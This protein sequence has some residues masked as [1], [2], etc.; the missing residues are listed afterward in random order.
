VRGSVL[1]ERTR[2]AAVLTRDVL[3]SD[4]TRLGE[5]PGLEELEELSDLDVAAYSTF[6]TSGPSEVLAAARARLDDRSLVPAPR[7]EIGESAMIFSS[8]TALARLFGRADRWGWTDTGVAHQHVGAV[9]HGDL[10][11]TRFRRDD[12]GFDSPEDETFELDQSGA[13]MPVA[14]EPI[15][16]T[17]ILPREPPPSA[18]YP[19]LIIGHG[20]GSSRHAMVTFAEPLT[21]AGYALVGIDMEGHG[22]RFDPDD[23]VN[24]TSMI[25]GS[26]AG[27]SEM[28][29]GF[30]DLTGP[31]TTLAL[32]EGLQNLSAVRDSF[33]QSVL[34][35]SQLAIALRTGA[36][37]GLDAKLDA[38]HLAYLGESFGSVIGGVLAGVEPEIELYVLDVGG[39]GIIDIIVPASPLLSSLLVPLGRS[40]YGIEGSFDRFHPVVALV[41]ALLDPA[42]PLTYAPHY[43]RDRLG[44]GPRHVVVIETMH[45][46]LLSNVGTD[47][48]ARAG[49]FGLLEPYY[50]PIEGVPV[51]PSPASGNV[52]GQTGMIVQY[53]PATHGANWSTDVGVRHFH[54]VEQDGEFVPLPDSIPIRN[55]VRETFEQ[56]IELLRSHREG[57]PILKSTLAPRHD[58]DDD[59]IEDDRDP[60]P[61]VPG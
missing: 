26:F 22:T 53:A 24:N 20:L 43:F 3:A 29:D 12:A 46:E 57:T 17:I 37:D 6:T 50:A 48:L 32:L 15:P 14:T 4:G 19:V 49:G 61:Y 56:V 1:R 44:T 36:V 23:R 52:E 2:H 8:T 58:F 42:D 47:A 10:H 9:I 40:V 31:I 60:E 28:P 39:G 7:I 34:D 30:G 5:A 35:L 25:A 45:D 38:T 55:P 54:P 21:E 13:P 41:Q 16:V 51:V 11:R 18:G 33:R 59:G 27:D